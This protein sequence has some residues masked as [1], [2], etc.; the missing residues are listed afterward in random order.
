MPFSSVEVYKDSS[1][2]TYNFLLF[3]CIFLWSFRSFPSTYPSCNQT[4]PSCLHWRSANSGT[5]CSRNSTSQT[6]SDLDAIPRLSKPVW[7][8]SSHSGWT[9]NSR[10][11]RLCQSPSLTNSRWAWPIF[12][13][14]IQQT[15]P[16][17]CRCRAGRASDTCVRQKQQAA[18][19]YLE[20]Q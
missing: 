2:I 6:A 10:H 5:S 19:W 17:G 11:A 14:E 1:D 12:F 8:L 9:E 13:Y 4:S 20:L 15:A 7:E 16:K 18:R 3:L